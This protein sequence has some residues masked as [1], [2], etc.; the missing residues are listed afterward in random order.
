M[1][2]TTKLSIA[3]ALSA[4]ITASGTPDEGQSY[5]LTCEVRGD[6]QLAVNS[7]RFGWDKDGTE[8]SRNATITFN[9]LRRSDAGEY[10][11]S[12]TIGSPYL[13]GTHTVTKTMMVA[14][15]RKFQYNTSIV[16]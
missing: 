14:V 8:H 11:C 5:S 12:T 4:V 3:P 1:R 16:I 7:R 13:T 15:N 9:P 2:V 6:E 10:K